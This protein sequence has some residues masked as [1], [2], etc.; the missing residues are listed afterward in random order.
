MPTDNYFGKRRTLEEL[1]KTVLGLKAAGKTIVLANGCFDL[2]HVGHVRYLEAARRLGD[3]LVLALNS[4]ASVSAIK[5]AGRPILD[6]DARAEIVS[7]MEA[8]DWVCI[9]SGEDV[10]EV[11]RRLRPDIHAKGTD[12]TE[13]TVPEREVVKRLGGRTVI[14][15][16][17]K[18]HATKSIIERIREQTTV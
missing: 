16:D 9:F 14:C 7:A 13:E 2:I 8:V 6:E 4:D 17:P 12:Y 5:G 10:S 3:C 1:E 18:D 11:I 15:G